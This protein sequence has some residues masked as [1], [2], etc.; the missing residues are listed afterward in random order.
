M[1]KWIVLKTV[2][3]VGE[4][5][6]DEAFLNYVKI[7]FSLVNN[8]STESNNYAEYFTEEVLLSTK[9]LAIISLL[10]LFNIPNAVEF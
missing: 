3:I 10:K 9:E 4:G 1:K 6:A 2:L 5:Y 8:D 7:L